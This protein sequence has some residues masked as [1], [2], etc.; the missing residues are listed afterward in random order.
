MSVRRAVLLALVL[1]LSADYC[2]P[3]IPGVFSFG[4]EA[5]FVDSVDSRSSARA[6][7]ALGTSPLRPRDTVTPLRAPVGMAMHAS[8]AGHARAERQPYVPRA[9]V[10]TSSP[11]APGAAEDH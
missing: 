4:T 7:L 3:S 5:F 11:A 10:V 8:A 9:H 2:D 1:Y 6:A